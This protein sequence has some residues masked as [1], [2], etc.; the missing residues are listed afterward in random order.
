MPITPL[1]QQSILVC[2][3]F[4][5]NAY[6]STHPMRDGAEFCIEQS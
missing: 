6:L 3:L 2:F 1:Q 4:K 5:S